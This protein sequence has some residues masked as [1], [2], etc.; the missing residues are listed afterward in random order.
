MRLPTGRLFWKLFVAFWLATVLCFVGTL[1]TFMRLNPSLPREPPGPHW[2]ALLPAVIG[3][4]LSLVFGLGLAWY[5]SQPLRHLSL[6]LHAAAGANFGVRV[7]PLLG[8]R[9]DEIVDLAREFDG[10][11]ARLQQATAQQ[12]RLFHDI[13]HELRSP[14]ARIQAAIGLWEQSLLEP[15]ATI[16]RIDQE[17][18]R[19][20]ALV[21]ELLTLHKLEAGS[22]NLM[23]ERMDIIELLATIA[24]NADFEAQVRHCSV[25]LVGVPSFFAQIDSEMIYCALENVVRNAV[26]FTAPDT[27]VEITTRIVEE[28]RE[29]HAAVPVLEI[30]VED[31]GPGVPD[32]QR[33]AIFEPFRRVESLDSAVPGVGLGLAISRR[34]IVLHG[35]HIAAYPRAG[36]GLR[37]V[38]SI[39]AHPPSAAI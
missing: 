38:A 36:G 25:S 8:S 9:R 28:R 20:D 18:R 10:M 30:S 3:G 31:R 22:A 2:M 21:E 1:F 39:P 32:A 6:A 19:I 5:L 26:K 12:Q 17:T 37:I 7:L 24:E 13:S 4:A 33:E 27:K 16:Q 29:N 35:G 34:A 15:A 11:A 14:L 23:L